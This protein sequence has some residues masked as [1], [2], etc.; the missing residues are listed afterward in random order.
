[1]TWSEFEKL[2]D[3]RLR[4]RE[5]MK[6]ALREHEQLRERQREEERASEAK[7]LRLQKQLLLAEEKEEGA[8]AAELRSIDELEASEVLT[9][10]PLETDLTDP[11][12][13]DSC[14]DPPADWSTFSFGE[15]FSLL[16]PVGG[17][18]AGVPDS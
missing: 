9:A 7:V 5:R 2:R 17:I 6:V 11:R 13:D 15:G 14:F 16:A 10:D 4:L 3:I 12:V 18:P 8:V 1:M